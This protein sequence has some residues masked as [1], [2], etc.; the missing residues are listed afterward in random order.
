MFFPS[1]VMPAKIIEMA[2]C[3]TKVTH[4]SLPK[5]TQLGIDHL[6]EIVDT[7]PHLHQ[8]E[9]F[10]SRNLILNPHTGPE[11]SR[12]MEKLLKITAADIKQLN[13]LIDDYYINPGYVLRIIQEWV[14]QGN[15]LPTIINIFADNIINT[16]V[17]LYV[18]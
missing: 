13:V 2:R 17:L 15:S 11:D 6:E 5:Y 16:P 14:D 8:L 10:T 1:P 9:V 12:F 18:F 3:C 7:M 4:L